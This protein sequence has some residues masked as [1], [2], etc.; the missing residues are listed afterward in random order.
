MGRQILLRNSFNDI[1]ASV[2]QA[3]IRVLFPTI[4]S[5]HHCFESETIESIDSSTAIGY[6][7]SSS[8][9]ISFQIFKGSGKL[10]GGFLKSYPWKFSWPGETAS[11]AEEPPCKSR[12]VPC[13]QEETIKNCGWATRKFCS[14]KIASA[15]RRCWNTWRIKATVKCWGKGSRH[16]SMA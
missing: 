4:F 7:N 1:E 12:F 11:N 2:W 8:P 9:A 6:N 5:D 13:G 14:N 10:K 16:A 15:I 3:W